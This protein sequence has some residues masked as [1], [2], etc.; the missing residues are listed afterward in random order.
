MMETTAVVGIIAIIVGALSALYY[1]MG[2]LEHKV[3]FIYDNLKI[4]V[5]FKNNH[6]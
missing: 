2:R 1:K 6:K 5:D 4:I 3:D